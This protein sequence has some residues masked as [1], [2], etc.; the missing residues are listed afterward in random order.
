MHSSGMRTVHSS[1]CLFLGGLPQFMLG[2][3]PPGAD[4]PLDQAPPGADAPPPEWTP[5]KTRHTPWRPVTRHAGI[6][7]AMHA[8]IAPTSP[9]PPA[10]APQRPAAR[11][12]GIPP[13]RHA[14]IP[15]PCG[16]THTCKNI[17]FATSLRT[18]TNVLYLENLE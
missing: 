5:P 8:G 7:P 16:Q 15:L 4:N 1:S 14:G 18:V 10:P 3:Q 2:Y 12:A 11:H 13:A 17:T 9:S 6:P